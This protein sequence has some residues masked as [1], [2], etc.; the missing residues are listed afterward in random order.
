MFVHFNTGLLGTMDTVR[1]LKLPKTS[2]AK[3]AQ[4]TTN[5]ARECIEQV[6]DQSKDADKTLKGRVLESLGPVQSYVE[7]YKKQYPELLGAV[8]QYYIV[9]LFISRDNTEYNQ[10][11]SPFDFGKMTKDISEWAERPPGDYYVVDKS[12]LVGDVL[13]TAFMKHIADPSWGYEHDATSSS[14]SPYALVHRCRDVFR[15]FQNGVPQ[16]SGLLGTPIH[17]ASSSESSINSDSALS[18]V[19][20]ANRG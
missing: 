12:Y 10:I 19:D 13:L 15:N 6:W 14:G 18:F 8:I 16:P 5:S 9:M 17:S 2:S 7:K 4:C 20:W 11:L 1:L 3:R